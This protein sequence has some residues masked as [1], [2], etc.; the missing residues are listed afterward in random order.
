MISMFKKF[1]IRVTS[2]KIKLAREKNPADEKARGSDGME[3]RVVEIRTL[4]HA[5]WFGRLQRK[6]KTV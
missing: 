5:L 4:G 1:S 2:E 6:P 3:V